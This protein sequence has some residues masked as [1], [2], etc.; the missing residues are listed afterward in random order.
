MNGRGPMMLGL[1]L[2]LPV[3][4]NAQDHPLFLPNKDVAVVYRLA[5]GDMGNGA[6]KLQVTYADGG[7]R[8]RID[9]FRWVEAKYPF[10]A[11]ILDRAADELIAING[12]TKTYVETNIGK[13]VTPDMRFA[14]PD[15]HYTRLRVAAVAD[16]PCTDWTIQPIDNKVPGGTV[17][18]T[19]DGL[20]LRVTQDGIATPGMV[21]L[22][23]AYGTVPDSIFSPPDGFTREEPPSK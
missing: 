23:I 20:I 11:L 10:A 16:H 14:S 19:D 6:Q 13:L 5:G 8:E 17:C 18:V 12:E 15:M 2:L 21:A 9:Y 3:I 7:Q 4:A 22:N 1:S